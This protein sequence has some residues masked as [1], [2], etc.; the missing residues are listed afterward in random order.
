MIK[1]LPKELSEIEKPVLAELYFKYA[2]NSDKEGDI[3][4]AVK[5]YRKCVETS[6]DR[7]VNAYLS[8]ALSN[9][10]SIYDEDGKSD[11]AV[12]YLQESLRLDELSKNYNGIYTSAM[13][14]AEINSSRNPEKA[15]DNLMKAKQC[16]EELNETFYIASAD[17][18]LGDFYYN[19]RDY[20]NALEFYNNAI[21]FKD[22]SKDNI[23]KIEMRIEDIKKV[24]NEE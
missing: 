2:L 22:L 20:K 12:K 6:Q 21:G 17:V 15:L 9:L 5:Y 7:L 14:L 13:K 4:T 11:M 23:E 3:D 8:S 18:A 16:A 10:A 1:E 24:Y 19:R